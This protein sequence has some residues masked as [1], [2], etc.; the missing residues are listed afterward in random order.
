MQL[1]KIYPNNLKLSMTVKVNLLH[2]V[3]FGDA[4]AEIWHS[5]SSNHCCFCSLSFKGR[6]GLGEVAEALF[7]SPMLLRLPCEVFRLLLVSPKNLN[8]VKF[9]VCNCVFSWSNQTQSTQD[10][11]WY[12]AHGR[13]ALGAGHVSGSGLV[14]LLLLHLEGTQVNWQGENKG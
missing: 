10:I 5:H 14:H 1:F 2:V 7:F 11:R 3:E 8:S 4:L 6:I 12:R 9:Q 13:D